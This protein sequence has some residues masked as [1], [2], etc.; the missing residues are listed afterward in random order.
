MEN[1][2]MQIPALDLG[3][4][5]AQTQGDEALQRQLLTLF[6]VQARQIIFDL[7]NRTFESAKVS[8]DF[9]HLLRGS[10][11]AIGATRVA[12]MAAAYEKLVTSPNDGPASYVLEALAKAVADALAAIDRRIGP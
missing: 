11:L 8:A 1:S 3:H 7:Q 6:R 9:A 4:L 5:N 10:A 12:A 2:A